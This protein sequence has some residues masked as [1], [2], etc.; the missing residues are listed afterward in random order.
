LRHFGARISD[1]Y[2]LDDLRTIIIENELIRCTFLVD[3]GCDLIELL[4]KPKDVDFLWRS[5]LAGRCRKEFIPTSYNDRPFFDHYEGGWQELFPHASTPTRYA[6]C[7][8][9]FHGEVWG[10]PWEYQIVTDTPEIV[11]VRFWVRTLRLPFYLERTVSLRAHESILSFQE[12]VINEG[13]KELAF[14][15]G[16]HPA[17]G[18]P[19]LDRNCILDAPAG[20]IQLGDALHPWPVDREGK[21][22]SRMIPEISDHE[23]MKYLHEFREGWVALT[24]PRKKL[25]IGLVFDPKIFNCVWLWHEFEYTQEYPWFGRAYV[26][27]VEPF[28]SLP[29]A[30][31]AGS[32]LLHLEGGAKME[33][34]LLTVIYEATGVKRI[35]RTGHVAPK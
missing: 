18:P 9:G 22:H 24:Q 23:I 33:T 21:D 29:G 6:G 16:H 2:R 1:R 35:S 26:L 30:H 32:R 4:Y 5:P 25:G 19:F 7:G 31:E 20:K 17:F 15:W 27:G 10:L 13:R 8:L 28:S 14:M 34:S 11:A 3:R 12:V